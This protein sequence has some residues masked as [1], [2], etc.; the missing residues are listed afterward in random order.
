M[1]KLV[2]TISGERGATNRLYVDGKRLNLDESLKVRS[3]SP[4]GFE[5]GYGGSG[6]AQTALAI[7]L[8]ILPE[9]WMAQALYQSFKFRF[10]SCWKADAF[11]VVIDITDF[12]IDHRDLF[13]TARERRDLGLLP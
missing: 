6:P 3:H 1:E 9:Q 4:T 12:L 7:C 8:E 10:V 2:F 5:W 13:D 11:E